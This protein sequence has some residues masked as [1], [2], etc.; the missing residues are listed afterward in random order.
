MK[1]FIDSNILVSYLIYEH[2]HHEKAAVVVHR[3]LDDGDVLVLSPQVIGEAYAISTSSK[4]VEKPLSLE[5]F[6]TMVLSFL[7]DSAVDFVSPGIHAMRL[8]L[9]TG[10]KTNAISYKIFD[11][12]LYGT[13][14]EHG[15]TKIATINVKH[16]SNLEGIELVPI[17]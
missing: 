2:P 8:A 4:R 15:I 6:Q 1:V 10:V 3:L 5:Q 14:L 12:I 17:P 16:F 13:M 11:L 7:S 9:E